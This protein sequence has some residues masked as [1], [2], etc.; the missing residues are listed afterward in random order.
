M[1]INKLLTGAFYC[2]Y[3]VLWFVVLF[4]NIKNFQ[5]G[6]FKQ[7]ISTYGIYWLLVWVGIMIIILFSPLFLQIIIKKAWLIPLISI[8]ITLLG[9]IIWFLMLGWAIV[10]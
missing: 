5:Y 9:F 2:I 3:V 8:G 7:F 10:A 6:M 4:F 1:K